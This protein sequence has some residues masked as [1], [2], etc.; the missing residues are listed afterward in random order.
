MSREKHIFW[1][2]S[3]GRMKL[4]QGELKGPFGM[5]FVWVGLCPVEKVV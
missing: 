5:A 2:V 3:K 1:P 4:A